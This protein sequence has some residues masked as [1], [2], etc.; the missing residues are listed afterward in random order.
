MPNIEYLKVDATNRGWRTFLQGLAID[1]AVGVALVL[2]TV[3]NGADG[4]GDI[5]WAILGFSLAKSVVQAVAAFVMRRFLDE[6][7]V[8]TPLP[9]NPPGEPSDHTPLT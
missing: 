6:S 1:V 9:P 5:Q 8:P 3:F 2:V 7:S 4:W